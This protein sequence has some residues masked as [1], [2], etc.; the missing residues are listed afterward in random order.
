VSD[1]DDNIPG[2]EIRLRRLND[3]YADLVD[4]GR[5]EEFSDLFRH[6]SWRGDLVG[7]DA[8]LQWLREH[9]IVY[10][11]GTPRTHH[12]ISSLRFQIDGE[13]ARGWSTITVLQQN[14]ATSVIEIITVNDYTDE[15]A[16]IDGAWAF[17]SRTV[18][19]RLEGDMSRH[20][21]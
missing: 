7:S 18:R 4:A 10:D 5:F 17:V 13:R 9:V 1:L 3:R 2:D 14:P 20:V 21:R 15:Y 8:V 19:R 16:I 11:D 12:L 6:G